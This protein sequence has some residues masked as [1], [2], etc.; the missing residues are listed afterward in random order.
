MTTHSQNTGAIAPRDGSA[1]ASSSLGVPARIS[2]AWAMP[3]RATFD[4]KPIA[5]FIGRYISGAWIDPFARNSRFNDLCTATNDLSPEAKTTH[6]LEALDFLTSF[7]D[8]S[9][10]GVLFDPPYSPRQISECYKGL[11]RSVHMSD[12]QSSFYSKR[13]D[14]AAA[15]IKPGGTALSFGWNSSGFGMS[16]GFEIV[17]ILIVAH[18]GAHNDTIC[19]AE[20]KKRD[21]FS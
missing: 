14:A 13:K 19:V 3:N 7:D 11:G 12:T 6:H 10:D 9:V 2:R 20:T 1:G 5:E 8:D 15:V 17:E 21:L 18:G 4:I 16:R